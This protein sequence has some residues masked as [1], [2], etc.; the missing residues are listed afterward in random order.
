MLFV[1]VVVAVVA[2]IVC[3]LYEYCL[4]RIK[5]RHWPYITNFH[6]DLQRCLLFAMKYFK[7]SY[8][9]LLGLRFCAFYGVL[10]IK[11]RRRGVGD[12]PMS[13]KPGVAG[14]IPGFSQS[15]G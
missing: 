7:T 4:L 15:V 13:C 2:K 11:R 6:L 10:I 14:S 9:S 1:V 8:E 3:I 12:K 5:L